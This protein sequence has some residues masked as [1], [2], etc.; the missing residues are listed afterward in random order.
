MHTSLPLIVAFTCLD[1]GNDGPHF[2]CVNNIGLFR[3]IYKV[4]P[5]LVA[6]WQRMGV[7]LCILYQ[8]CSPKQN[9]VGN[10]NFIQSTHCLV[11]KTFKQFD[12]LTELAI[13]WTGMRTIRMS[14]NETGDQDNSSDLIIHSNT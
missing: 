1:C 6:V 10:Q 14:Q 5:A 11:F 8:P 4:C 9:P 13:I 3:L 2:T 7:W 12:N